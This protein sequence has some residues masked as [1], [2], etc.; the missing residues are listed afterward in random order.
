MPPRGDR[1]E[2]AAVPRQVHA[3]VMDHLMIR[4][5]PRP[6]TGVTIGELH[7]DVV[8]EPDRVLLREPANPR[9]SQRPSRGPIGAR[10]SKRRFA[11]GRG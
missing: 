11:A 1:P 5:E 8:N 3:R 10:A 2:L 9:S 7:I 4:N 6:A